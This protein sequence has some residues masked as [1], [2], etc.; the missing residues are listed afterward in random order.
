MK[1]FGTGLAGL[2]SWA[3]ICGV[4]TVV[5]VYLITREMFG[6]RAAVIAGFFM[7]FQSASALMSRQL[8]SNAATPAFTVMAFYFLVR[9]LRTAKHLYF[10]LAG[11][12]AGFNVYY[13]A[14][15][16]LT[17]LTILAFM[18]YMAAL[19][20]DFLKTYWT[21]FV[22]FLAAVVITI[23]PFLAYN[24]AYPLPAT[25][26]PNDR[27]IWLHHA[28]LTVEYGSSSWLTIVWD[29]LQQTLAVFTWLPD[30]SAN[31]ILD[32]PIARPLEAVL[33]VLG[34]AWMTWRWKDARFGLLAIWFW[35]TLIV[36]GVLTVQ[37]PN[38]PRLVALLPVLPIAMAA[39]LDH[40]GG[41]L[42][43]AIAKSVA[44]ARAQ[45]GPWVSGAAI[46]SVVLISGIQNWD[47]YINYYLHTHT[48]ADVTEQAIYVQQMGLRY[49][50][51]DLGVPLLYFTHGD[52]RFI[53]PHADGTD[54]VNPSS[55]LPFTD[56]GRASEKDVIFLV[57][58]DMYQ[59]LPVLHAYYPEGREQVHSY[60]DPRDS[61]YYAPLI[62]YRVTHSQIDRH[63]TLLARFVP[64]RGQPVERRESVIGLNRA[65]PA[66]LTYPVQATFQG[67]IVAPSEGS[68]R[69]NLTGS[70][71]AR[72]SIDGSPVGAKAISLARGVHSIL[73]TAR[74]PD[75]NA[76][77]RV[78][79][80][81]QSSPM[82]PIPRRF[83]WDD[84]IGRAWAGTVK[85]AGS[86]VLEHRIDGFLGFREAQIDPGALAPY[87][88][89]WSS[90]LR[91]RRRGLYGFMLLSNGGSTLT[92]DGRLV[93]NNPGDGNPHVHKGAI[94]LS[95]GAHR[96]RVSYN[97][98]LGVGYL[99]AWWTPPGGKRTFLMTP[100]LTPP[101]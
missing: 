36:G 28:D 30:A 53:N 17:V 54:A 94:V 33:I 38:V 91:V 48:Q 2:R 65:P 11:L 56:N 64:S 20:R 66:G 92:V 25:T 90:N 73:L 87:T 24:V 85:Q 4:V 83:V 40:F 21:Q 68:Y 29:Q 16:R 1:I 43:R 12:A 86:R 18:I 98:K 58:G 10:V 89:R 70:A 45:I 63:R 19:H 81:T 55:I 8:S 62:T 14:G 49:R 47:K 74:L 78:Q 82:G 59:Y 57:W 42:Q 31:H 97:W 22:A 7:A 80:R 84:H 44:S 9:G 96:L 69:F 77:I 101:T 71:G 3:V 79:W 5:F 32:Y 15:G 46:G 67:G 51:Y 75:A 60:S 13:F 95:P 72:L 41:M 93:V 23:T 34:I 35:T 76:R 61:Y 37:A 52:N 6:I 50:Y 88:A 100:D 26:Y 99:E 27:F 39:W